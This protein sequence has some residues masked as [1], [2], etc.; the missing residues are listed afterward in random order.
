MTYIPNDKKIN[1]GDKINYIDH[2]GNTHK[3]TMRELTN[4]HYAEL[5]HNSQ[6]FTGVPYSVAFGRH[7]WH[8]AAQEEETEK[9]TDD[10]STEGKQQRQ[11]RAQNTQESGTQGKESTKAKSAQTSSSTSN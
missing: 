9:E 8:H 7:T 6:V 2:G 1:A 3:A 4:N 5:E 11:G 10:G